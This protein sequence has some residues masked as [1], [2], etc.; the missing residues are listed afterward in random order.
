VVFF[1]QC[2]LVNN[3]EKRMGVRGK[4]GEKKGN[5]KKGVE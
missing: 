3:L 4:G 5:E 2:V 1:V